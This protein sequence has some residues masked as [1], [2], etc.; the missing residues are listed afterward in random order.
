[1]RR[2]GVYQLLHYQ[3]QQIQMD[4]PT[5]LAAAQLKLQQ[6]ITTTAE[7]ERV[8]ARR[9]TAKNGENNAGISLE[10]KRSIW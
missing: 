9:R 7:V 10:R 3:Q 1:M 5:L 4:Y 8:S 6:Q 2:T